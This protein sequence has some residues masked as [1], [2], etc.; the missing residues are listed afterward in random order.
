MRGAAVCVRLGPFRSRLRQLPK[1][2]IEALA[3]AER[4]TERHTERK[5]RNATGQAVPFRGLP[6][7]RRSVAFARND[8]TITLT[9]LAGESQ[10]A[11]RVRRAVR[12]SSCGSSQRSRSE[13][14]A[15]GL[16]IVDAIGAGF[17][18]SMRNARRVCAV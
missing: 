2:E 5:S 10:I 18:G 8:G 4:C 7:W 1:L 15:G 13:P 11:Y 12:R 14:G 3:Q 9:K 6:R 16:G 17:G